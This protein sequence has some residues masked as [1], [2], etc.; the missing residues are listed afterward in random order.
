MIT[1]VVTALRHFSAWKNWMDR[2]YP[3]Y[4]ASIACDPTLGISEDE[5]DIGM[6]FAIL[7]DG[8]RVA[9]RQSCVPCNR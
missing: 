5:C 2:A 1:H 4:M 8:R 9:S 3:A 6:R 7:D